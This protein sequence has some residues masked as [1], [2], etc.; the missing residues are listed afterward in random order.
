MVRYAI[1]L[2]HLREIPPQISFRN[3]RFSAWLT[4]QKGH[5]RD[6]K[7]LS[8]AAWSPAPKTT[9]L[10]DD[11]STIA[12]DESYPDFGVDDENVD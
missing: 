12:S 8:P 11:A 4:P 5:L 2:R 3:T 1:L 10:D 7:L 6:V 9:Q